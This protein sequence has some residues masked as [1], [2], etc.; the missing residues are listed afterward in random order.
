MK[1]GNIDY[2]QTSHF[3]NPYK[4][5]PTESS[6]VKADLPE[7]N[8]KIKEN[9]YRANVEIEK[10]ELVLKPD[11]TAIHK[12]VGKKHSQGGT[13]V[14]LEGGSFVFSADKSLSLSQDDLDNFELK[15]TSKNQKNTPAK[16]LEKNVDPE[17][18]NTL[19]AILDDPKKDDISKQSA[20]MMLEK[21]FNIIGNIAYVQEE[22]K[23]FPQGLPE[24]SM[25]TAP[26]YKTTLK[27]EIEEND[28]YMKYGGKVEN[29][30]KE[31]PWGGSFG[32]AAAMAAK[33]KTEEVKTSGTPGVTPGKGVITPS[34]N[35]WKNY[36]DSRQKKQYNAP[37]DVTPEQFYSTPGLVD[38]MKTLDILPGVD[39]DMKK[40]DDG[41]WGYRHQ[42]AYDK[43]FPPQV[44]IGK[45]PVSEDCPCGKDEYGCVPCAP[46]ETKVIPPTPAK[47]ET[48]TPGK[49]E[50]DPQN[51]IPVNWKF[52]PWQR[53]AQ[54]YAGM[55]WAGVDREMPMRSH[56]NATFIDP[57]LVNPEQAVAD[58]RTMANSKM[59][60]SNLMNPYLANAQKSADYGNLINAIPGIRSQYDNQNV[61]I[62]NS[63]RQYNNQ[64]KNDETLKNLAF[65]QQYWKE[66]AIGRTNFKNMRGALGDNWES[67]VQKQAGENQ[68]LAYNML[69]LGPKPAYGFDWDT[70][71]LLR[72]D[73][74]I[75]D[76][77]SD[78]KGDN[79]QSFL[80]SLDKSSISEDKKWEIK[81]KILLGKH[82]GNNIGTNN[83]FRTGRKGG[84][85]GRK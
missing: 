49:V 3:S 69:T 26:V 17:H 55:R 51:G 7:V 34:Q 71:N 66:G 64:I 13:N 53:R 21:Y 80:E 67:I 10:D 82:L 65:D 68:Q 50:G 33:K 78:V 72:N 84:T 76:V 57:Q 40:A 45:P 28:Q 81:S 2:K 58:A 5:D 62:E 29:P 59:Q 52:T 38:Y 77:M 48:L 46:V 25:G 60:S 74:N 37:A 15:G 11:L 85:M 1:Q 75:M 61:A 23:Q 22:K 27:D 12:T 83:L 73:K 8:T 19:V 79:L 24:F 44:K 41:V 43:F 56:Y 4:F 63:G 36:Y 14:F 18:Y 54:S 6:S 70:G 32:L 16:V 35:G 30:Y 39:N 9:P 31:M 20:Q 42:I 47:E